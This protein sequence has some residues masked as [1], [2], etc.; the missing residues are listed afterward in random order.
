MKSQRERKCGRKK[1]FKQHLKIQ[2][3]VASWSVIKTV[4][5]KGKFSE[6]GKYG[7]CRKKKSI[8]NCRNISI[9]CCVLDLGLFSSQLCS[10][11]NFSKQQEVMQLSMKSGGDPST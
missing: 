8:E 9:E 6:M 1:H 3:S 7:K 4:V 2:H 5:L 11:G 10:G